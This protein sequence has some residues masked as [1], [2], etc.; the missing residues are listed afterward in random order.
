MKVPPPLF[1]CLFKATPMAYGGSQ[2][3]GSSQSSS[4]QPMPQPQPR[5]I[6]VMSAAYTIADSNAES[7][8]HLER[9][10]IKPASS[11]MLLRFVNHWATTELQ[12]ACFY[13]LHIYFLNPGGNNFKFH[14]F[15]SN[16][17]LYK[18]NIFFSLF[19]IGSVLCTWFHTILPPSNISW[20]NLYMSIEIFS[21][22][23]YSY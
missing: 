10:Q 12:S 9:P 17:S 13:L 14:E 3:R 18:E 7:L 1:F 5:G 21:F 20:K 6:L 2:A 4:C 16:V 15:P 22:F 19:N 11:W 23:W 8:T